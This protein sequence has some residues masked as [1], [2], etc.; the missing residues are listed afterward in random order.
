MSTGSSKR[1]DTRHLSVLLSKQLSQELWYERLNIVGKVKKLCQLCAGS[2]WFWTTVAVFT[3]VEP[4]LCS[5]NPRGHILLAQ[6]G[7]LA[8]SSLLYA[9]QLI[10]VATREWDKI[11]LIRAMASSSSML[12]VPDF[13][14]VKLLIFFTAEGEYILEFCCL[15]GGWLS[16][17]VSPGVAILRCFRVFR[18]L[19]FY[20]ITVFRT[21]VEGALNPIFGAAFVTRC[22]KVLRFAIKALTALGNEMF[23]LTNATRGGLFLM[24]LFFYSAVILGNATFVETLGE[25]DNCHSRSQCAYTLMRLAFYD[26]DAF[27]FIYKLTKHHRFLFC[28]CIVYLCLTAFGIMNGLV[29][30]FGTAFAT[31]SDEA[32]RDE[33]SDAGSSRSSRS[34]SRDEFDGEQQGGA[35]AGD[36]DTRLRTHR[37]ASLLFQSFKGGLEEGAADCRGDLSPAAAAGS[38]RNS[39]AAQFQPFSS[40]APL[41]VHGAV[42]VSDCALSSDEEG[43]VCEGALTVAPSILPGSSSAPAAA[44][45]ESTAGVVSPRDGAAAERMRS[46]IGQLTSTEK[47][48]V[49]RQLAGKLGAKSQFALTELKKIVQDTA[50]SPPA[51]SLRK[52]LSHHG[53][54]RHQGT[55]KVLP[56]HTDGDAVLDVASGVGAAASPR[57]PPARSQHTG[58]VGRQPSSKSIAA[59]SEHHH[60]PRTHG[61]GMFGLLRQ[62]KSDRSLAASELHH[63]YKP[64]THQHAHHHGVRPSPFAAELHGN[65][66][67]DRH[68]HHHHSAGQH[69]DSSSTAAE[70]KALTLNVQA[71]TRTVEAQNVA[72]LSLLRHVQSTVG[73]ATTA[74]A[75]LTAKE[76]SQA[77]GEAV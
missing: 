40:A 42:P 22:F 52:G 60:A 15:L 56:F 43:A 45:A 35:G 77:G 32:F 24:L 61:A 19:W 30:I 18:L 28:I 72:I 48:A 25:L 53:E 62:Q 11:I 57:F 16:I 63:R 5:F 7:V 73:T 59:A 8:I 54:F 20:E 76:H 9:V 33:D 26:G 23:R 65:S 21:A 13:T 29:G 66:G 47:S 3:L 4:V 44:A 68:H 70:V 37:L 51:P 2:F 67:G 14:I 71:L 50:A 58:G 1:F 74:E 12:A 64:H 46:E 31:A 34:G 10:G 6:L 55:G 75:P 17:F 49:A 36:E 69:G 39:E 41:T 38:R 27:D